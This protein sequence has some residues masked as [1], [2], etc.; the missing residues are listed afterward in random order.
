MTET[1]APARGWLVA[2]QPAASPPR[3]GV[4]G[5]FRLRHL[6]GDRHPTGPLSPDEEL[7]GHGP[8][9]A[10]G[11][12]MTAREIQSSAKSAGLPWTVA[13]GQD[14]FTPI[15]NSEEASHFD[16]KSAHV[17]GDSASPQFD[18]ARFG[19][20]SLQCLLSPAFGWDQQGGVWRSK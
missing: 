18:C 7:A 2:G 11:L 6:R 17:V 1:I 8:R 12:D 15:S 16:F 13:K 10:L 20:L 4:A 3:Q 19:F 5:D 14:T 9:Y